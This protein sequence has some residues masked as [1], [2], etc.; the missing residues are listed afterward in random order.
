MLC[1]NCGTNVVGLNKCPICGSP[2]EN[3]PKAN[4]KSPM[5]RL[6]QEKVQKCKY[7]NSPTPPLTNCLVCGQLLK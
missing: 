1:N 3:S 4:V 2:I 5:K 6:W 7:C